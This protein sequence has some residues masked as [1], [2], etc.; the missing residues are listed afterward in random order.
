MESRPM[1]DW[2][3]ATFDNQA[4]IAWIEGFVAEPHEA[5]IRAGLA[6]VEQRDED[7]DAGHR[8]LAAAE[9]VAAWSGR[10]AADLPVSLTAWLMGRSQSLP[11]DLVQEARAAVTAV[12]RGSLLRE[13]WRE[14]HRLDAWESELLALI[15]R[16]GAPL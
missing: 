9:V 10:P 14:R 1:T 5:A 3:T 12:G 4:A 2:G 7:E 6:E 16:L 8:V 13:R 11:G 15:E